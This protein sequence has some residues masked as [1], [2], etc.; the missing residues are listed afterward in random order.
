MNLPQ[1]AAVHAAPPHPAHCQEGKTVKL[2]P[3]YCDLH[4]TQ[5]IP[6]WDE[7]LPLG[8]RKMD[9]L[10]ELLFRLEQG[11]IGLFPA[12]PEMWKEK[13]IRFT[14]LRGEASA[15]MERSW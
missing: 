6:R 10:Q 2:P 3:K 4:F 7:G 1:G 9:A 11:M 8:N 5:P 14:S 12:I 15:P 13:D